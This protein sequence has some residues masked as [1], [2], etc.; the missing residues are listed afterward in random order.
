MPRLFTANKIPLSFLILA[1]LF[2]KF[3]FLWGFIPGTK[4]PLAPM[5]LVA[6]RDLIFLFF[7]SF[8]IFSTGVQNFFKSR[9]IRDPVWVIFHILFGALLLWEFSGPKTPFEILQHYIRNFYLPAW[10]LLVF[11]IYLEH[12]SSTRIE[13]IVGHL[14]QALKYFALVSIVMSLLQLAFFPKM[15]WESRPTGFLGDPLLNSCFI[16][17]G[18]S[19]LLSSRSPIAWKALW[20]FLSLIVLYKA[21]SMSAI[22][23]FILAM[24]LSGLFSQNYRQA[25]RLFIS[26]HW[27]KLGV[28]FIVMGALLITQLQKSELTQSQDA[29]T[30]KIQSVWDSIT[31][32]KDCGEVHPSIEGRLRSYAAITRVCSANPMHCLLG[33]REH[34]FYYRVDSMYSSLIINYGFIF[35]AIYL[36][37]FLGLP[38]KSL[39]K[40]QSTEVFLLTGIFFLYWIFG[41]FNT[42]FY[43]YPLNIV[44][45]LS[46]ALLLK[47]ASQKAT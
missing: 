31:C 16:F 28:V 4:T 7:L 11:H 17:L 12:N 18:I 23:A 44:F 35:F 36:Y 41:V 5:Y 6:I 8:L 10:S 14:T 22:L 19:A 43:K 42:S 9:I 27:K 47:R 1:V 24:I 32:S 2:S 3:Y 29:T 34:P 45:Y 30:R 20:T 15:M 39:Y 33:D 25:F 21:F 37:L 26:A 40:S 46:S 13:E 38:L